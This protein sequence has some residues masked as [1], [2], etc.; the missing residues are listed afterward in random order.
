[1]YKT[2]FHKD[3]STKVSTYGKFLNS[4]L[5]NLNV[6]TPALQTALTIQ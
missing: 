6:T 5:I 1:M 3:T 4:I 2:P